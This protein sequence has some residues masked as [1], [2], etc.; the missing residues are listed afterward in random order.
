MP[1]TEESSGGTWEADLAFAR[2]FLAWNGASRAV[3][4][5]DGVRETSS[6]QLLLMEI[7]DYN[8]YLSL[9]ELRRRRASGSSMRSSAACARNRHDF[10]HSWLFLATESG[11][12]PKVAEGTWRSKLRT[13]ERRVLLPA[14]D[15]AGNNKV[16]CKG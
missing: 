16:L 15:K 5:V 9:A 14:R 7:E 11:E 8:P 4:R 13:C 12:R 2:G 6:G 3:V 10:W 1:Y